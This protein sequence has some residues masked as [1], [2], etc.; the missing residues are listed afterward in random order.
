MVVTQG[1]LDEEERPLLDNEVAGQ[2]DTE[3][4]VKLPS[5]VTSILLCS[6]SA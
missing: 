5:S 1:R 3:G 2:D 6:P 4:G